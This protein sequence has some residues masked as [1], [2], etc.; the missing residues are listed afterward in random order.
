M[1]ITSDE[2]FE[3]HKKRCVEIVTAQPRER[4]LEMLLATFRVTPGVETELMRMEI[5][6]E[7]NRRDKV[8]VI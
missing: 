8:A 2:L 4:L 3:N 6:N 7:L 5:I 1:K